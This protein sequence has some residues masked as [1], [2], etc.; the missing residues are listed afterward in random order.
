M[1]ETTVLETEICEFK[2]HWGYILTSTQEAD[3]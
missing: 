2:S 3:I 1:A